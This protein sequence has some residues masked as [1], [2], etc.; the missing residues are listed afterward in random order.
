ML[1]GVT[2]GQFGVAL[3]WKEEE[4][5]SLEKILLRDDNKSKS[6]FKG[7]GLGPVKGFATDMLLCW[8]WGAK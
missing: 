4:Q 1:W 5:K 3:I 2:S 7:D 6:E 8:R